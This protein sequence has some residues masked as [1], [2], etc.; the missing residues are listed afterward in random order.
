[1]DLYEIWFN[2]RPGVSD[3]QFCRDFRAYATYLQEAGLISGFRLTRRKLGFGP[4]ELGE[5]HVTLEFRD[6]RH[7]DEAFRV[8]GTRAGEV[9]RLHAAVFASVQDF[10]SALYRDFPD[11][12]RQSEADPG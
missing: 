3:L 8:V 10:R 7:L 12:F 4:A 6:L 11:A 1:M 5:F 9:E 2:L